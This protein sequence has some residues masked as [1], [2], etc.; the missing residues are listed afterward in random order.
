MMT[1]NEIKENLRGKYINRLNRIAIEYPYTQNPE[2][3]Y[4]D[5]RTVLSKYLEQDIVE[6]CIKRSLDKFSAKY[7]QLNN[8]EQ[9]FFFLT[10]DL[11]S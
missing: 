3:F 10:G 11:L 4:N 5:I 6:W 1:L 7:D 9:S 2:L 8:I